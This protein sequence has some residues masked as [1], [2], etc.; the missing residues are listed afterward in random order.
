MHTGLITFHF[1]HHYGAQ[2]QAYAT[3]RAIRELGHDCQIIDFRLPHTTE[4]N[5]LF[6]KPDSVRALASNVHTALHYGSM[7]RRHDRFEAFVAEQMD[8][9]PKQYTSD[10][11][12][13]R[14]PP[15]YDVY[16]AGSDQIW[17]P[18]I[19]VNKQ[20]EPAFLLDFVREG[21]KIAY[22]PS[23]GV[24]TLSQPYDGQLRDYLASFSA[25]SARESRGKELLE[26]ITGREVS[27]VLD[28]TLLLTGD[29]WGELAAVPAVKGPYILC[30]FISDPGEVGARA[31]ELHSRTG[32]PIVQLAGMRRR[33]P[34]AERVVFDAGPREFLGLFQNAACVCTNSFHGSVFSLQFDRPFFTAMSPKEKAEPAYSRIYS[35]L[36]R[37]G[38]T[39][40]I[41]GL[42]DSAAA[43][44][45]MDYA[46]IHRKLA[47]ARAESFAYLKNA[48][49]G[50]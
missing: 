25:L 27:L 12:L 24:P 6:K 22:A 14:E 40:R 39:D 3:M 32:W 49:E 42:P 47:E 2:I 43:D 48:I 5:H 31:Q 44:A 19:Y 8:L 46:A 17:N 21:R 37:L 36:S 9:S 26:G 16:V 34:G 23:L 4:T 18:Y 29:Q 41:V 7:K 1:A 50:G 45:E 35:L 28:P 30:Y 33:L 15:A 11:E 38:C 13:R 10:E 20:F